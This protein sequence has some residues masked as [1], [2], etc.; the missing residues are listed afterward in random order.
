MTNWLVLHSAG[1]E[2]PPYEI[3][4]FITLSTKANFTDS[5]SEP[6]FFPFAPR[7]PPFRFSDENFLSLSHL[8]FRATFPI[9]HYPLFRYHRMPGIAQGSENF[10][11]PRAA[12]TVH[13]FLVL[14]FYLSIVAEK[15]I[16]VVDSKR[17]C[18]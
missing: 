12:L 15:I 3:Q 13:I 7:S 11:L 6:I 14:R 10:S 18:I 5:C 1:E 4:M 8:P 16:N 17:N 9:H 2:I